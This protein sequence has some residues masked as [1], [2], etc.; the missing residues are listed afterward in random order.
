MSEI[1]KP[2]KAEDEYFARQE[3][4]RRKQW[5][6]ERAKEKTVEEKENAKKLHWM[7]CPKCGMDL[8]TVDFQGVSIDRC[9]SCGGT[10]FDA[11]EIEEVLNRDTG[12]LGKALSIFK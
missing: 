3:F 4:E 8:A 11:G 2:S 12:F 6:A 10:F 1:D 7:K 5:A 9:T